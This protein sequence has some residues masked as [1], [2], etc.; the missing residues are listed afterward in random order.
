[1]PTTNKNKVDYF[2]ASM[3][4]FSEIN[5][6]HKIKE[7]RWKPYVLSIFTTHALI[8]FNYSIPF[9]IF[10]NTT[11]QKE[12]FSLKGTTFVYVLSSDW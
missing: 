5:L 10:H 1:L 3:H 4:I 12:L 9:S 11:K 8:N 6:P 2:L 7:L